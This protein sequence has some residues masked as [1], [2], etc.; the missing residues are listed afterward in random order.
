M[1]KESDK[2]SVVIPLYNKEKEIER[3]IRSV[4]NQ[5]IKNFEL[6]VINDGSKDSGPEKVHNFG[7]SRVRLLSQTN[8][9]VSCARNSGIKAAHN[10]L[11]AFLD[12][13][14][15]W[16]SCHLETLL[17]LR[18]SYPEAGMYGTAFKYISG[19]NKQQRSVLAG[20][21]SSNFEGLLGN[22]FRQSL[23]GSL[24]SSSSV[25]IPKSVF[26]EIGFFKTS[27]IMGEDIDMWG[28]VA[29]KYPVAFSA[30]PTAFYFQNASNRACNKFDRTKVR[31]STFVKTAEKE[32][33]AGNVSE[34]RIVDIRNYT[35]SLQLR[36]AKAALIQGQSPQAAK[37]ILSMISP[38]D[39]KLKITAFTYKMA[40]LLPQ[41]FWR[42]YKKP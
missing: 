40:S 35:A 3:A 17:R 41:V 10:N 26:F 36:T 27:E 2:F 6:I 5:T 11:I 24:I 31:V 25:C 23:Y 28:R 16:A 12:A 22:Y 7:D 13:D 39:R 38:T 33:M 30:I 18:T 21:P 14:D 29:L 20:I 9:G 1:K 34:E 19:Q 15:E 4:L 42:F 8:Q 32:I 37:K